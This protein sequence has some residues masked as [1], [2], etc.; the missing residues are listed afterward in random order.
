MM[1]APKFRSV[2][3]LFVPAL[4]LWAHSPIALG[5][6]D[7]PAL[8]AQASKKKEEAMLIQ[9]LEVVTSD[10]EATRT[11]FFFLL[12]IASKTSVPRTFVSMVLT[13]LSTISFTPTAAAR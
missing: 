8:E 1:T 10:V 9:Y 2:L 4:V 3:A 5:T 6:Q 7:S 13:G 11:F 12:A